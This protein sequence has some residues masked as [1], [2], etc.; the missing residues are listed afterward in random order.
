MHTKKRFLRV[1]QRI[2]TAEGVYAPLQSTR[3]FVFQ[4]PPQGLALQED[5]DTSLVLSAANQKAL[6]YERELK[7]IEKEVCELESV[8]DHRFHKAFGVLQQC[9]V[10]LRSNW[11]LLKRSRW[12]DRHTA[13]VANAQRK[14]NVVDTSGSHGSTSY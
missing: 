10:S 3:S 1:E 13:L 14:R 4:H 12:L 11:E 8:T 6:A 2:L 5:P 7:V 9:S